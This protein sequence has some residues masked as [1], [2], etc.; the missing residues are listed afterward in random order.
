MIKA[1]F[2][3]IDGT[4]ISKQKPLVQEN[5]IQGL[6]QLRNQGIQL[7]IASGRHMLELEELKIN[8]QFEFDG[9]LL[10]NGGYCLVHD[11]VIYDQKIDAQDVQEIVKVVKE[12]HYPCLFIENNRMYINHVNQRV[13]D[14]QASISTMIPPICQDIN[15]NNIYQIDPYVDEKEIQEI[16]QNTKHIKVTRWHDYAYDIVPQKGGKAAAIQVLQKSLGF[17]KEEMMAF[18]DGHNDIE[19]LDIVGYPIVMGNGSE[20]VK[21]H[22]RYICQSVNEDGILDGLKHFQLL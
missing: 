16:I 13:K 14:A 8:Q 1:I 6:Q 22:G 3:D 21:K 19:M 18:G 2:F 11:Q 7:F 15:I 5:V 9:Y 20:E 10:L 4:L 12:K 17:Q